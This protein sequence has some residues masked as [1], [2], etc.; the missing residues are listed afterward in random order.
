MAHRIERHKHIVL[1]VDTNRSAFTER[2]L[3]C[4]KGYVSKKMLAQSVLRPVKDPI[5]IVCV[6]GF[7]EQAYSIYRL[8]LFEGEVRIKFDI[9]QQTISLGVVQ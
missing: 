6:A 5:P 4:N 7:T 8:R 1:I 3:V 2:R 9:V